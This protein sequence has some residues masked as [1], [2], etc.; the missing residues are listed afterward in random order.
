MIGTWVLR[1]SCNLEMCFRW[2]PCV[3]RCWAHLTLR[4]V[5]GPWRIL[6]VDPCRFSQVAMPSP[7]SWSF[8][9]QNRGVSEPTSNPADSRQMRAVNA[10]MFFLPLGEDKGPRGDLKP[11]CMVL[12]SH[13][14]L[15]HMRSLWEFVNHQPVFV[16]LMLLIFPACL[17]DELVCQWKKIG[18]PAFPKFPKGAPVPNQA[19][20]LCHL[21]SAA[22]AGAIGI[23]A[24]QAT[25]RLLGLFQLRHVGRLR[26]FV[27]GKTWRCFRLSVDNLMAE[28]SHQLTGL[29]QSRWMLQNTTVDAVHCNAAGP[30]ADWFLLQGRS[31]WSKG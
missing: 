4:L 6:E 17:V 18:F 10:S 20:L 1:N 29:R 8:P 31:K 30:R 21:S 12:K 16:P 7:F 22:A 19:V 15:Q 24:V 5:E 14:V 23:D 2:L 3:A 28:K 26:R 25:G 13:D 11:I 9:W 27:L